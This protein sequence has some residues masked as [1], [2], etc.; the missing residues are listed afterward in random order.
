MGITP[1]LDVGILVAK[2]SLSVSYCEAVGLL[3]VDPSKV[4]SFTVKM[5]A[6]TKLNSDEIYWIL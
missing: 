1:L 4:G 3:P 5:V 2:C 6:G